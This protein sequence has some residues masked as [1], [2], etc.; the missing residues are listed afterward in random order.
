MCWA[1][2]RSAVR[3]RRLGVKAGPDIPAVSVHRGR[4]EQSG[5][6]PSPG[7]HARSTAVNRPG[8]SSRRRVSKC[9]LDGLQVAVGRLADDLLDGSRDL[10][11]GRSPGIV[12]YPNIAI[13]TSTTARS[14][15]PSG[16]FRAAAFQVLC[17]V[18]PGEPSPVA[19]TLGRVAA[20]LQFPTFQPGACDPASTVRT[21]VWE[22]LSAPLK[23][24]PL[25][26]GCQLLS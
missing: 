11:P 24:A 20:F 16:R 4:G 14:E 9:D 15:A 6:P 2:I 17:Q 19:P 21:D 8:R 7:P 12:E 10:V 13:R 22:A 5:L 1:T 23:R 18:M 26:P 3:R 25:M